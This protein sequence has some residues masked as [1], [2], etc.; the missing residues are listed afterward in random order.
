MK[1]VRIVTDDVLDGFDALAD[2]YGHVPPLIMWRAWEL[3]TYR[4]HSLAEPVLDLGCGDG[5]FFARAFPSIGNV[6]GIDQDPGVVRAAA[7]SGTYA[8]VCE[9]PAHALPF[10]D[11]SFASAFANC[12][13]EHMS[14]LDEVL[15]EVHRV[16]RSGGE[17]LL[18]VV[19]D[20]LV[21]W[22]PLRA[23][24]SA[25]GAPEQGHAAQRR[26]EDYHHLVNPLSLSAWVQHLETAGF[27]PLEW[28]PVMPGAAGWT[29]V[30]LDQLWHVHTEDGEFGDTF[31]DALQRASNHVRGSRRI[32]EGLLDMSR[33]DDPCAGVVL[34]VRK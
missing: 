18:S 24:L 15:R 33:E 5:R 22:A 17:F 7:A 25:C 16:L 34:R 31:A 20:A 30:L 13:L 3:A 27:T 21:E 12:S 19:T 1:E 11:R 6:I 8:R 14:H 29:F 28:T 4:R 10:D 9:A 23:L 32:F 26:H 2:M